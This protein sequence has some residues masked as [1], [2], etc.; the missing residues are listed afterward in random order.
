MKRLLLSLSALLG[1]GVLAAQNHE[2]QRPAPQD[3]LFVSEAVEQT[4][5]EVQGM[6]TNAKLAWMFGNCFPNTLDTTVHFKDKGEDGLYDTFVYTGDIHAMWLRDSGAQVWPYVQLTPRDEHLRNMIAGV[7]V[8][9]FK[10]INTDP[11]ANAFNDGATGSH[12]ESDQTGTPIHPEVHER[13]WEIDSHCYPIRL[14]YHYWKTTGDE[15]VFGE[16][17]VEA[18]RNILTTFRTQQRKENPG[19]YYF[20][21]T[22]DRSWIPSAAKDG[23]I[24]SNPWG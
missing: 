8:R 15:S 14:A 9:Q 13:K 10:L 16:V 12:W 19:P 23:A 17:W 20:R 1:V 2:S 5:A 3:R 22:T 24:R 7:I 11:Y 21:R 4:I 6:L 18:V